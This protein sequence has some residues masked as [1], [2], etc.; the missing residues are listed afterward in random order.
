MKIEEIFKSFSDHTFQNKLK[1][2]NMAEFAGKVVIVTGSST[3]IG[4]AIAEEFAKQG[5]KVTVCGRHV[6]DFKKMADKVKNL[7]KHEA[8]QIVGDISDEVIQKRIIDETI[9]KFEKL[10]IL[11][12]NAGFLIAADHVLHPDILDT[13]DKVHNVNVRSVLGLTNLAAPHLEKTKGNIINILSG[14]SMSPVSL[15]EQ[16]IFVQTF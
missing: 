5:A 6:E 10:D 14:A 11:V 8:L 9:A 2:L 7:S 12:N 4:A 16:T 3:G 15:E 13:Y 1:I